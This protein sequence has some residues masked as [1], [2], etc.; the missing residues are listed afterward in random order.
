MSLRYSLSVKDRDWPA[1]R[2]D[3]GYDVRFL[4]KVSF[5]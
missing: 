1:H 5:L 4:A 2:E 3:I